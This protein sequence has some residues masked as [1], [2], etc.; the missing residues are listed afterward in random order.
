MS[1]GSSEPELPEL[2]RG[3]VI[4]FTVLGTAYLAYHVLAASWLVVEFFADTRPGYWREPGALV[5]LA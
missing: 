4:A 5:G 3:W 2:S 1:E